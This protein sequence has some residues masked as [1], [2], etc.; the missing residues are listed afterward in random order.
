MWGSA[1]SDLAKKAHDLQEQAK[2][3]ASHIA[4][5]PQNHGNGGIEITCKSDMIF[6]FLL[7]LLWLGTFVFQFGCHA[8]RWWTRRRR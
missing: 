1:F 3:Q 2:E 7:L 6:F 5:R 8:T 4:V